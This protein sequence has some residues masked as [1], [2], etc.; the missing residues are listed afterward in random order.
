DLASGDTVFAS[1]WSV[2][3]QPWLL[4]HQIYGTVIVPGATYATMALLA[5]DLPVEAQEVYIYEPIIIGDRESR[6]VQLTLHPSEDGAPGTKTFQIH[7]RPS[8]DKEAQWSL[9]AGGTLVPAAK[10]ALG[11]DAGETIDTIVQRMTPKLTQELFDG[12]EENDLKWGPTW[13]TSLNALWEGENESLGE[14]RVG[15]ELGAHLTGEALHPVILDLCTGVVAV[16]EPESDDKNRLFLPLKYEQIVL[17]EA[18][19][20]RFYCHVKW[21]HDRAVAQSETQAFDMDFLTP[22]GRRFGGVRNFTV[23]RAPRQALLRGLG[24]DSSR[25]LYRITWRELAL[26]TPGQGAEIKPATWIQVGVAGDA[27]AGQMS[28]QRQRMLT[29]NLGDDWQVVDEDHLTIDP[30]RPEHWADAF[31]L[32]GDR[33]ETLAGIVWQV[34]AAAPGD[35]L[36]ADTALERLKSGFSGLL[37]AL[38]S[39]VRSP[40]PRGVWV[41][42]ERAVATEPGE[43]VDP[44]QAAFWGFGRTIA[45]EEPGLRCILVDSDGTPDALRTLNDLLLTGSTETQLALRQRKCLVPRVMPWVRSGQLAMPSS[46]DYLLQPVERGTIDHLDLVPID[47]EAPPPGYVQVRVQA[48]GLNFRD[49][50]NV[51]DL[52]PGDPGPVGGELSGVVTALGDG[53]TDLEVGQ[54]VFGFGPGAFSSRVNVPAPF[55]APVPDGITSVEATTTPATMLTAGLAFDWAK[56]KKGE[57]VLI[58]AASGGVGMAAIQYVQNC[59]AIVYATASRPKQKLLRDMGVEHIYDSRSTAFGD[60]ILADTDGQG[61]DVVLNSLT[62]EGFVEATVKATARNGRFVEI[63]KINTWTPEQMAEARPDISYNILAVDEIMANEPLRIKELMLDLASRLESGELKPLSYR[64]Y[65]ITEAKAA[66]RFMQQARHVGK[67]VLQMPAALQ[68]R[69]DRTYLVTGG[70]GALGLRTAAHLAQLGAGNLVLVSRREPDEETQ[71]AIDEIVEQYRTSV[72]VFPG[73]VA[74]EAQVAGLLDRIDRELPPLGGVAHLAGVVDDALLGQQ[75]WEG[76]RTVLGPKVL[77]ALHIDTLTRGRDLEFLL[78]YSSASSVLGSPGQANYAAANGL[79]DGLA[80]H[81]QAHGLPTTS[82]NWGPWAEAGM[83]ASEKARANLSKQGL[84]A[85]RPPAALS[86]LSQIVAHGSAQAMVINANWQRSAKLYG[87][88]RPP[89]LEQ[90]L[91]RDATAT[92]GDSALLKTLHQV[93]AGQRAD[94]LTEHLQSELQQILALAAPPAPDSRFLELGMD[95]LMAVELRNRLLAQFGSAFTISSTVVFDYPTI[96]GLAEYLASATPEAADEALTTPVEVDDTPPLTLE[97]L[98]ARVTDLAGKLESFA[99]LGMKLQLSG[100]EIETRDQIEEAILAQEAEAACQAVVA[101]AVLAE[102]FKPAG[103]VPSVRSHALLTGATGYLG[104]FLLRDLLRA[105]TKVTA[106]VRC[107]NEAEGLSR[108]VANLK[109]M[110]IW[111]PELADNLTVVPGDVS[112]PHL[113]LSPDAYTALADTADS[114]FHC[115]GL[116]RPWAQYGSARRPNVLGTKYVLEF[117][118]AGTSKVLH[119]P[120]PAA[121]FGGTATEVSVRE[122]DF[123][124]SP[125][126]LA[127]GYGQSKWAG[128]ALAHQAAARGLPVVV[129]RAGGILGSSDGSYWSPRDLATQTISRS[130]EAGMVEE[131]SRLLEG[132]P[133]DVIAHFIEATSA[134]PGAGTATY[135]VF[136]PEVLSAA[137]WAE[138]LGGDDG[139]MRTVSDDEWKA[140]LKSDD[141]SSPFRSL[142]EARG[143]GVSS[144][145]LDCFDRRPGFDSSRFQA[146][147]SDCGIVFPDYR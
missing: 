73:D 107:Q 114:V 24:A 66:F 87:P 4:D 137:E 82:I 33:G 89:I 130:L 74:E 109:A 136:P 76:F 7:S 100:K 118:A 133:V 51:L 86:A 84:V 43:D 10:E 138:T 126:G 81:R 28:L 1:R 143:T 72:H 135:H 27:L 83:A 102:D 121:S 117:A 5:A 9:N 55:V 46:V 105:G 128:E 111:E 35:E 54:R 140:V 79:L 134:K 40:L 146:Q 67:I 53:V 34:P 125:A 123:P 129:Y 132:V 19:P 52:Y 18:A 131:T 95:S 68:P 127:S 94:F 29:L 113:G 12:F 124:A 20:R 26:E 31:K 2:E 37:P 145:L 44:V 88:M 92:A 57:R 147:L 144:A 85:L 142:S 14:I 78:L 141:R 119:L 8:D 75:S 32:V 98:N 99:S 61:V 65:P 17:N 23:K 25:L 120:A 3:N 62:S 90:L 56:P 101:D 11:A 42:T 122:G 93:P 30:G 91:P 64:V 97:D 108:V 59:G 41:V 63:A 70:L 21:H 71:A 13:R 47:V 112:H 96:R 104:G 69:E 22:E 39:L 115:A 15:E 80:A 36:S 45:A 139:T 6:E 103:M 58:H 110:Q 16:G 38:Q 50:L 48:A 106:L 77:G 49:V 60:Q 116:E